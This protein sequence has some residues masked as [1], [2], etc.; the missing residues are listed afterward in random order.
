MYRE[1]ANI[2][3]GVLHRD[4]APMRVCA[5]LARHANLFLVAEVMETD[6]GECTK[7]KA[8]ITVMRGV[9]QNSEDHPQRASISPYIE[10]RGPKIHCTGEFFFFFLEL[11]DRPKIY[12]TVLAVVG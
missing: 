7:Y 11:A 8:H 4:E 9:P 5:P 2:D 1:S 10:N 12:L 6:L 3:D